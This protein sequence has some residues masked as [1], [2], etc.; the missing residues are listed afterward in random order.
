[1]IERRL[2]SLAL[3][4]R[5]VDYAESDRV[6]TLL[7]D[8]M[9]KIS[10]MARAA[11][12]SRRRFGGALGLFIVGRASVQP[13]AK[14]MMLLDRFECVENLATAITADVVK[15]AHGSY[16]VEAARDLWPQAQHEPRVFQ[17]LVAALRSL[18]S[19]EPHPALLRAFELQLLQAVG[20]IPALEHCVSCGGVASDD[21]LGFSVTQGGV[22]CGSCGPCGWPLSAATQRALIALGK[23]DFADARNVPVD[24]DSRREARDLMLMVMRHHLGKDLRSLAF[25]G[26]LGAGIGRRDSDVDSTDPE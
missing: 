22:I 13:R 2:T 4:A 3:V 9:G 8:R 15:V 23:V 7:T 19:G 11:R 26:Q 18:A 21:R 25:I 10:V 24:A 6:I 5:S 17:L 14:G 1:M 12:R 16:M 20:L